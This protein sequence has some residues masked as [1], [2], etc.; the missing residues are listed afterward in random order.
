MLVNQFSM[1]VEAI[2]SLNVNIEEGS[3]SYDL[4]VLMLIVGKNIIDNN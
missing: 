2:G 1:T 4:A 3:C